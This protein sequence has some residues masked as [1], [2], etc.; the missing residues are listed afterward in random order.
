MND[1]HQHLFTVQMPD[2]IKGTSAQ[3]DMFQTMG[4]SIDDLWS[5]IDLFDVLEGKGGAKDKYEHLDNDTRAAI[6]EY[7][8][9]LQGAA[10]RIMFASGNNIQGVFSVYGTGISRE[11][12]DDYIRGMNLSELAEFLR[13]SK[14]TRENFESSSL[15]GLTRS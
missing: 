7:T 12:L 9:F 10:A 3:L 6:R 15:Q 2:L 8:N 11:H 13:G 4:E 14:V 1:D 5:T